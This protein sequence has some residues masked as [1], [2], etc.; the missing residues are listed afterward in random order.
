MRRGT[1]RRGAFTLVELLV[2]VAIIGVLFGLTIPAILRVREVANRTA[3]KNNLK[4][5][6]IALAAY[7]A[8]N[9][10]LPPGATFRSPH[11]GEFGS[12]WMVKL[13]PYMEANNDFQ[14]ISYLKPTALNAPILDI[15]PNAATAG[16][17]AGLFC[18]SDG[19]GGSVSKAAGGT[20]SHSNYLAYIGLHG[21]GMDNLEGAFGTEHGRMMAEFQD[22]TSNTLAVGEYLTGVP[23]SEAPHDLRGV[24]WLDRPGSSQL[25]G[26]ATPNT[27]SADMLHENSC[28]SAPDRNLPCDVALVDDLNSAASRSRHL[29]GVN[30]LMC[31]GSVRWVSNDV[32]PKAWRSLVT[33]NSGDDA[34]AENAGIEVAMA[35]R[36]PQGMP[37]AAKPIYLRDRYTV[38]F[39]EGGHS[40]SQLARLT[41]QGV[42]VIH[43]FNT[44]K[45]NALTLRVPP[46]LVQQVKSLRGVKSFKQDYLFFTAGQL[47]TTNIKRVGAN[48]SSAHSG[49]G[50][51]ALPVNA[52]I[53]IIDTGVDTF[54]PD[55]NVV[56]NLG[57]NY[58]DGRDSNGH[59]THVA[60]IAAAIDNDI[61]VVGV[62]PGARLWALR[63]FNSIGQA[64][65]S[66]I[67]AALTFCLQNTTE[68]TVVN[69]SSAG[70]DLDPLM[71][72]LC[73]AIVQNGV[74]IVAA[75]G[76]RHA[77]VSSSY[78]V[79]QNPNLAFQPATTGQTTIN[80]TNG[81]TT[82]N[83][84]F[85]NPQ[86][87][88]ISTIVIASGGGIGGPPT[89]ISNTF[90]PY[91]PFVSATG[92]A[93]AVF[94]AVIAVGAFADSDGKP[95]GFGPSLTWSVTS[96]TNFNLAT[97][98]TFGG[99]P[100]G[101]TCPDD[102]FAGFS[103]FGAKVAFAAP[104]VNVFSTLPGGKYGTLAGTSMAAAHVTG[105]VAL[106]SA[107]RPVHAGSPGSRI[108]NGG[109][110]GGKAG[111]HDDLE[112]RV[113]G[114]S[115]GTGDVILAPANA[116][117]FG[118][119]F[120]VVNSL[121]NLT[122]PQALSLPLPVP[123]A[124][125]F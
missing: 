84:N 70:Q 87:P 25:T 37:P 115:T 47:V 33:V 100:L 40:A 92:E 102:T 91:N 113:V 78:L 5:I 76:D 6:G 77:D 36:A 68:I 69:V 81:T 55:L 118:F 29:R 82:T 57:F 114:V 85:V 94:G 9:G 56:R 12:T 63:A 58:S 73:T 38:M 2:V 26:V 34:G 45:T 121:I 54:H 67:D 20:W 74:P 62:A 21:Y 16:T 3:C 51:A 22:G 79:L 49:N 103:N 112:Q 13:L 120:T 30:G 1:S 72:Q 108:R 124:A 7:E 4:Q 123:N 52:T 17:V 95:G 10:R 46:N 125:G 71:R 11:G 64:A 23:Q 59:G 117:E 8:G 39:G 116:T 93:P 14:A 24:F 53:A 96:I 75:A 32:D 50:A 111:T 18:P 101:G 106:A 42:Q 41:R 97:N 90:V 104:G 80:A 65:N 35:S 15:Q 44:S 86:G 43:R 66:D 31:D 110:G 119:A 19:M 61:G 28:Y 83:P 89:I 107:N 60:G 48:R 99:T 27:S 88:G 105:V 98:S 122:N 109:M